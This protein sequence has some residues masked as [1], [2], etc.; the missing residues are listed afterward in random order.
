MGRPIYCDMDETLGYSIWEGPEGGEVLVDF[1]VRPGASDF[2]RRLAEFGTPIIL[3]LAD[4]DY[5][6]EAIAKI[7]TDLVSG[8]IARQDLEQVIIEIELAKAMGRGKTWTLKDLQRR[9]P[10]IFPKGPIFDDQPLHSPYHLI[11]AVATGAPLPWWIQ[12][13]PFD[14]MHPDV[15]GLAWALDEFERRVGG[16]PRLAGRKTRV[17]A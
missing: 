6:A 14:T 8:I 16:E 5:A 13:P 15:G 12:V 1:V 3:T 10:P 4:E 9:I 2:L 17:T 7:G 11:K